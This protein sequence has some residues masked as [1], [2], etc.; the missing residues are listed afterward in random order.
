MGDPGLDLQTWETMN[1]DRFSG[2]PAVLC[3]WV[4]S[5]SRSR[6]LYH[7]AS[8]LK[9]GEIDFGGA[10]MEPD[11]IRAGIEQR[12]KRAMDL[13]IREVLFDRAFT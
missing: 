7:P 5:Q 8:G 1:L 12:K 11:E 2:F 3:S 10:L 13:K 9:D 4:V 6:D